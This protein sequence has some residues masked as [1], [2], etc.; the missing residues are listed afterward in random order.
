MHRIPSLLCTISLAAALCASAQT[1]IY[2]DAA[3]P[4]DARVEDALRRMTLE[5]KVAMCHAQSKFSSPGVPRLGIPELWWSDGPHGV[6]A[7]IN[8]NDWDYS[9]WTNDSITAFPAL[10]AL[11]AT[12]NRDL[13]ALYGKSVGEE[14]RYRKKEVLLGPGVNICRTPL[15][16]R[17]FEYMGE[18]PYLAGEMVVPYVQA[19]QSNGVAACVKHFALNNQEQWRGN[20]NVV[21]SDRALYEIYLPAFRK[22]VV[23]GGA[24]SVMGA[25][26]RYGRQ[27]CCHNERLL[28]EILR[29]EWGFDGVVV[30]DWGGVHST[31][32]AALT[33][34]D[35]EMGT[36]TNGL[37][38]ESE[39]TFDDYYL[40]KP[41][42]EALRRGEVP[43]ERLDAKV[44]NILRLI[45]RTA[46]RTDRP[47]GSVAT[48]EHYAA[49]KQ[50]GDEAIVL[51]KNNGILPIQA[52]RYRSILVV[53]ENAVRN[54][55]Q[56]GGSSELKAKDM[57]S[58]LEALRQRYGDK[59]QYTKGYVTG[60]SIYGHE[61]SFP[62]QLL[63]SLRMKAVEMA[64]KADLV[65]YIG[66]LNKNAFQ[67]CES[68]DRKSY[69]LPWG[70]DRIIAELAAANKNLIVANIS[71]NAYAMP[72]LEEAA[73]VMQSWY[74]GTMIGESM[75]AVLSGEV[76][77]SG[78]LPF[79][80]PYR[81][82]DCSAHHFDAR[83]Y[84]GT[85]SATAGD[86]ISDFKGADVNVGLDPEVVYTDD[87]LVGYRWYDTQKIPAMFAFGHGL[88]YTT[89]AY[90]KAAASARTI[91]ADRPLE[92][93]VPVTNTG[94]RAGK[95]VV[96]LYISD[97][98]S[99]VLRPVKELKGFQKV[100]IEA[101]KTVEVTF[102]ITFDDLKFFDD[103][104][105]AWVAEP[106][107]F[108]ALI[109]S[110][111]TDIRA[112]VPFEYK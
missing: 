46:M 72:W 27:H 52:D 50:I 12:W 78:R 57:F 37:T 22:A 29:G 75:A 70:Q 101:G 26:N 111:S 85:E 58:P 60:R 6:R 9:G 87:I 76:N 64:R 99:S 38:S 49:A 4:I 110:S 92:I 43:M 90:G 23:E 109:G 67:D 13:S 3:Q 8:W 107:R 108:R 98:K 30:S 95:E 1:P 56:G 44:R 89:F 82:E 103:T 55:A 2:L 11:A 47:F 14:A 80:F 69:N 106:G 100:D 40:G 66:G 73:A 62:Q 93:T 77:P 59:V 32:E 21:V 112:T 39:F 31:R 10:T 61:D 41:Y 71:G 102:T 42:R 88:S 105:H 20:V 24:W 34:I 63:D 53:G 16:G 65:I 45:F 54:L 83:S 86:T 19:L 28:D 68:T 96:Q 35:V 81:L 17:N 51:L 18:D 15:N 91:A 5:E 48:H 7:E 36:G 104:A 25:Y 79:S 33:G 94:S 74:L 97:E 84:P